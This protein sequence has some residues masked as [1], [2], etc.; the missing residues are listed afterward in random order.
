VD[1][2]P[3]LQIYQI[4]AS[5]HIQAHGALDHSIDLFGHIFFAGIHNPISVS[6]LSDFTKVQ[7][8]SAALIDSI[9]RPFQVKP[10][11]CALAA[12]CSVEYLIGE[13]FALFCHV[14]QSIVN[15][16]VLFTN[17]VLG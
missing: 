12:F 6:I 4:I 13:G 15:E 7:Q 1:L 8:I 3:A 5:D 17:L 16:F 14:D 11:G 2:I 9:N 10:C